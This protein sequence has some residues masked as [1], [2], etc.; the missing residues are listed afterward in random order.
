M[1]KLWCT[2]EDDD[3]NWN[4]GIA[5]ASTQDYKAA[6]E[7]LCLVENPSYTKD[8]SYRTWLARCYIANGK[9]ECAWSIY[10][11]MTPRASETLYVLELIADECYHMGQFL[12]A[13]KAFHSLEA[14]DTTGSNSRR[15]WL[16][17]RGACV[18]LFQQVIFHAQTHSNP[19]S[20]A[21]DLNTIIDILKD[22][23]YSSQAK[24]LV[25]AFVT[26]ASRV[27]LTLYD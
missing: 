10:L 18:G 9:P 5:L 8:L 12:F 3:F 19:H 6:E 2:A 11:Q 26:G 16:G 23:A 21:K 15:Y 4:Y 17:K 1:C 22:T 24:D 13:A 14:I 7:I 27:G 20:H 25:T